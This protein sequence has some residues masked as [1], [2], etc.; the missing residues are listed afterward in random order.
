VT[1]DVLALAS[2]AGLVLAVTARRGRGSATAGPYY[3][4]TQACRQILRAGQIV[5]STRRE[6]APE[7]EDVVAL[8]ARLL[9]TLREPDDA[10]GW[11]D[12]YDAE[13]A[14]ILEQWAAAALVPMRGFAYAT[15]DPRTGA[16]YAGWS[17]ALG[18][19]FEVAPVLGALVVPDED[20]LG[21]VAG[22]ALFDIPCVE[23]RP[24]QQRGFADWWRQLPALVTSVRFAELDAAMGQVIDEIDETGLGPT[25]IRAGLGRSVIR[26]LRKTGAG[27]EWLTEGVR[28]ATEIAHEGPLRVLRK[29]PFPPLIPRGGADGA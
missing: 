3:H 2:V 24:R 4:G 23:V 11:D 28:Y 26:H 8:R 5:A 22:Q 12:L 27:R 9:L 7:L 19:V 6:I 25:E 15:V 16:N 10:A 17:E 13:L 29:V 20:W 14:E 18:C 21:C 1:G